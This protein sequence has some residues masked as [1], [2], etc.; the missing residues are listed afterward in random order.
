M[1]CQKCNAEEMVE[2][3]VPLAAKRGEVSILV[4]KI[5]A[6]VC[7]SCGFYDFDASV[8]KRVEEIANDACTNGAEV[9]IARYKEKNELA[10]I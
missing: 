2:G 6:M 7:S 10:D 3:T 8:E 5:P 4:H 9:V 1:R